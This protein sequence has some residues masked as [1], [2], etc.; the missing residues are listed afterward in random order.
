MRDIFDHIILCKDCGTR[1]SPCFVEKS[2]FQ[3]RAIECKGCGT[4]IVHPQDLKTY[5]DFASLRKKQFKVKLR[6][7]GNSYAVS[8]PKE[9]IDFMNEQ[10]NRM[11]E[12]VNLCLEELGRISLKFDND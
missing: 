1:M 10:E 12:I 7:V 4:Q 11:N 8:I 6:L 5:E 9:I 3:L 2:G